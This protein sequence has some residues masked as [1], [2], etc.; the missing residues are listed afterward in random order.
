MIF[1]VTGHLVTFEDADGPRF[2]G[3]E[4]LETG[5]V[6]TDE[7]VHLELG[8]GFTGADEPEVETVNE[9]GGFLESEIG[10][11]CFELGNGFDC[12]GWLQEYLGTGT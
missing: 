7:L 3:K 1:P 2:V 8:N 9:P 12:T 4:P 11:N 6:G 5:C 10:F